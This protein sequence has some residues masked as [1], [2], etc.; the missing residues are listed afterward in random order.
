MGVGEM[1]SNV[2]VINARRCLVWW[3]PVVALV[4]GLW[5]GGKCGLM[6]RGVVVGGERS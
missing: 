6:G 5:A 3:R 2:C 4:C 1:L